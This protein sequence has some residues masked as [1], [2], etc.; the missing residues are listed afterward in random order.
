MGEEVLARGN[1]ALVLMPE[2]RLQCVIQRIARFLVPAQAVGGERAA[3]GEG[4]LEV[5]LPV[6]IDRQARAV[7]DDLQHRLDPAEILLER[8]APDLHLHH[9]VAALD[10]SPH[11]VLQR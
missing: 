8:R 1:R 6:C 10:V 5:E 7:A 3:V 4:G 9:R 2:L 11:L